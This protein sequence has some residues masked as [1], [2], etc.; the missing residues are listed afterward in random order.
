MVTWIVLLCMQ[1]QNLYVC[2]S[3]SPDTRL[4]FLYMVDG[5]EVEWIFFDCVGLFCVRIVTV[6]FKSLDF[7]LDSVTFHSN[8]C[9]LL[10]MVSPHSRCFDPFPFRL[11]S[12]RI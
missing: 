3:G 10:P 5:F 4:F 11:K 9:S 1:C 6:S 7:L 2:L 12:A 8:T